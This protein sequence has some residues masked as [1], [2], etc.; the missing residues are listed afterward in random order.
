MKEKIFISVRW[1]AFPMVFFMLF[2]PSAFA[3]VYQYWDKNGQLHFT[4][5][6]SEIPEDQQPRVLMKGPEK[7]AKPKEA[8]PPKETPQSEIADKPREIPLV[9]DL[10]EEKAALDKSHARLMKRKKTLKKEKQTLKTPEQ[11]RKYRKRVTRLN[12]E[13][14]VYKKRNSAF[15]KKADAY[16]TAVREKG[17]E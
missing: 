8:D 14:S 1:F 5:A 2:A 6:L 12:D 10:N 7:P 15:Q 9:E 3:Q 11:V 16:N 13:I 17:E 4:N